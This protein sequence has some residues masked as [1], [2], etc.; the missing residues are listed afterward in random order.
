MYVTA[1]TVPPCRLSLP[2]MRGYNWVKLSGMRVGFGTAA[3]V[4]G[5]HLTI[6]AAGAWGAR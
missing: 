6:S 1:Q 3:A 2:R 5:A 4:G